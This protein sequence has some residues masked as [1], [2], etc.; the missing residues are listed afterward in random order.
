MKNKELRRLSRAELLELLLEQTKETERLQKRLNEAETLLAER[1]LKLMEAGDI[2]HAALAVNNVMEAAQNAARQYLENIA[3]ME[4]AAKEKCERLIREATRD[5]ELI[6]RSAEKTG[7]AR[8]PEEVLLA[9]LPYEDN[10][11]PGEQK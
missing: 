7:E 5:A 9:E 10:N 4:A 2:A 6:L 1:H 11:K 8:N 3:A